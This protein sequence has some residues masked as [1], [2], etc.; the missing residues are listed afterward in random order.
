MG[1]S[2]YKVI[3]AEVSTQYTTQ[4]VFGSLLTKA[5]MVFT[6]QQMVKHGYKVI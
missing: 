4:T 3:Q 5:K 1:Q 2:G 6:I